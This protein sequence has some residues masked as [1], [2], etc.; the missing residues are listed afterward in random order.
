MAAPSNHRSH[1]LLVEDNPGDI[2]LIREA[3]AENRLDIELHT[4]RDG[5]EALHFL[6]RRGDYAMAPQPDLILL[7]LNLPKV[8]G[9]TVLATIE[10]DPE[11]A[12][13]PVVVLTSSMAADDVVRSYEL[14][15]NAYLLKPDDIDGYI[16]VVRALEA[17][18]L[19]LVQRPT[20]RG[21]Q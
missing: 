7:D 14:R 12:G 21:C 5:E 2:R 6:H 4:V 1:L 9:H 3:L 13:I 18:W 11:L 10:D 15:T 19:R 17:F 20:V 8:D 16:D